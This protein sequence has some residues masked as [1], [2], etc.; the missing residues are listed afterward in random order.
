[1][2]QLDYG[3]DYK[4]AHD[5]EGSFADI[6]FMPNGLEGTKLW[7]PKNTARENALRKYLKENWKEK[8]GY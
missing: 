5:F 8:Y 1:M 6:E 4:Y 7:D 3:K 2:K